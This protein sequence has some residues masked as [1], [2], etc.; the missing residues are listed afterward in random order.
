M[1]QVYKKDPRSESLPRTG[2]SFLLTCSMQTGCVESEG[3]PLG[4]CMVD[5]GT[6]K[7]KDS[8]ASDTWG[9]ARTSRG[10]CASVDSVYRNCGQLLSFLELLQSE[11]APLQRR[12]PT[13]IS[14]T[15]S[16]FS[17]GQ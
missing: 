5:T 11:S 7:S 8:S 15:R 4:M 2:P 12:P 17:C 10:P 13:K 3:N 16:S 1:S 9:M 14:Y 6:A